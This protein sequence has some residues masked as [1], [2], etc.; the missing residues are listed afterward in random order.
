VIALSHS[1]SGR[2]VQEA[3]EHLKDRGLRIFSLTSKAPN[4]S[5]SSAITTTKTTAVS[6]LRKLSSHSSLYMLP[7][8][9]VEPFGG[10]PTCSIVAMEALVNAIVIQ[11]PH[12]LHTCVILVEFYY[13]TST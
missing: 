4:S 10:A 6:P 12:P 2:E 1:G 5:S 13:I 7:A 3:V 9:A 8:N 11:V